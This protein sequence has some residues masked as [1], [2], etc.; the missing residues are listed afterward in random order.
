MLDPAIV[1]RVLDNLLTTSFAPIGDSVPAASLLT[2][3]EIKGAN[4]K[5]RIERGVRKLRTLVRSTVDS[6]TGVVSVSADMRFAWLAAA[7][8]NRVVTEIDNFNRTIRRTRGRLRREFVERRASQDS[9]A[10]VAAETELPVLGVPLAA[11]EL[12][13]LDALLATLQMPA[14]V[15]VELKVLA[16]L[17]ATWPDLPMPVTITLPVQSS[18]ICTALVKPP[19]SFSA[20]SRIL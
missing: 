8:A 19:F 5:V 14:G 16:I 9:A 4:E 13:G 12:R 18:T 17:R 20:T 2:L 3:L 6:R 11:T 10:L 1:G 7:V 15:P